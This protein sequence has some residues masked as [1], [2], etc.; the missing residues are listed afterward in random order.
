M[1]GVPT[2]VIDQFL[3]PPV[4]ALTNKLDTNGP[5][6]AGSHTLT[7][8]NDSGTTRQVSDTFGVL[9][10][11]NG[12]I[13]AYWGREIGWDDPITAA[14]G[15]YYEG[16]VLQVVVQHQLLLGL[17]G[18]IDTDTYDLNRAFNLCLWHEAFPGRIGLLVAPGWSFDLQY[19]MAL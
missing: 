8:W 14:G 7:T 15:T 18:W 3:H 10:I 11:V 6:T 1:V 4:G 5:Y 13:P 12:A 9:A 16:R 19:L 2:G 17:G